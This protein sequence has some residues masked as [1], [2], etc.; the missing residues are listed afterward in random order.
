MSNTP[1][2]RR[3]Y[4]DADKREAVVLYLMLGT[5]NKV[6][7][8]VGI[9]ERTLSSWKNETEWWGEIA[10]SVR[11]ETTEKIQA[12]IDNIIDSALRET[13]DRLDH[14]D[15]VLDKHGQVVRKPMSGKDAA[16]VGAVFFDK[17]QIM[18]NQPTSISGH[19]DQRL[20]EL[21]ARFEDIGR[22]LSEKPIEGVVIEN[23]VEPDCL[24]AK[25]GD[26]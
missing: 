11:Q 20:T 26:S 13:Q 10:I 14:G 8:Q 23:Q 5:M 2:K 3:S 19:P 7:E 25:E 24:P 12:N 1:L 21:M 9:P 15:A 17:R 16:I 6:A 18:D 4:S 22:R